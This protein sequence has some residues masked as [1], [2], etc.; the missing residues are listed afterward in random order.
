MKV[1]IVNYN[2][3][4]RIFNFQNG[5]L[6]NST[7]NHNLAAWLGRSLQQ[8]PYPGDLELSSID[9]V[10]DLALEINCTYQP[11]FMFLS[12]AT[13]YL[14]SLFTS[15]EKLNWDSVR[16]H[17]F[18]QIERF[19]SES[20]FTPII[21]GTGGTVH[22][23]GEVDLNCL[24]G[25]VTSSRLGPIYAGLYQPSGRDMNYLSQM[26]SVQMILPQDRLSKVWTPGPNYE[27]VIPDYLLVAARGFA[28]KNYHTRQRR[29]YRVN[30]RDNL[31]PVLAPE[32]I[33]S[34]VDIAALVKRRVRREKVALIVAEG[35][36]A[37]HFDLPYQLCS[38]TYWWYT[39]LPGEGQYLAMTTGKHLLCH[40]YPPGYRDYEEMEGKVF[41]L[42][43]YFRAMPENTLGS[44]PS[45]RSAAVG[46]RSVMTHVAAGA[47]ITIE[48]MSR[49][50]EGFGCMAVFD[51]DRVP[52]RL[53]KR[54][55]ANI[56]K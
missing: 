55:S 56:N 26:E 29:L 40:P 1:G 8:F 20:G 16:T 4:N 15:E 24:D 51:S 7:P 43:G 39:Y 46:S 45:I 17:L 21:V 9:W 31:I 28:F 14:L 33:K 53:P 47:D 38:N 5:D 37:E 22:L 12:Y 41:P 10:T 18:Q 19:C 25:I 54:N 34:I 11:D 35:I 44:L 27:G 50:M 49:S 48:S 30:A 23:E 52:K 32:P 3:Q 2:A 42:S 13:P 6:L 36:D